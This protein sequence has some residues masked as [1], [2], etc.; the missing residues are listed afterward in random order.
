MKKN[1]KKNTNG[2]QIQKKYSFIKRQI[3]FTQ[4]INKTPKLILFSFGWGKRDNLLKSRM[5]Q[6]SLRNKLQPKKQ[7]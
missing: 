4:Q 2:K 5:S 1:V 6:N 3:I 7:S